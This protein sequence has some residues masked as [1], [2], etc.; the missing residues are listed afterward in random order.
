MNRPCPK[1]YE[2][3][4]D[5][6]TTLVLHFARRHDFP[7]SRGSDPE[8]S[9]LAEKDLRA[10]G[11]LSEQ[12]RIILQAVAADPGCTA[13]EYDESE[14]FSEGMFHRRLVELERL[15]LVRRGEPRVCRIGNKLAHTW[16]PV[17]E[18]TR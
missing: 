3:L 9:R 4:P 17:E 15:G 11:R 16:M 2:M 6:H 12:R 1:C 13:R 18:K 14:P 5:D 8:T 10:S 7:R